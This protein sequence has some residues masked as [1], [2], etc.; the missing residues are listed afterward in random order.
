[1]TPWGKPHIGIIACNIIGNSNG[2]VCD[3]WTSSMDT[4]ERL[5]PLL[6]LDSEEAVASCPDV[7]STVTQTPESTHSQT[8][9]HYK[10]INILRGPVVW[11]SGTTNTS[12]EKVVF[13]RQVPYR[14]YPFYFVDRKNQIIG[15]GLPTCKQKNLKTLCSAWVPKLLNHIFRIFIFC[16][17]KVGS[18]L[19]MGIKMQFL[20]IVSKDIYC[21]ETS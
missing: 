6:L 11:N 20:E 9:D 21:S 1:M 16:F 7:P 3:V 10:S 4:D 14:I 19:P 18:F 13:Y 12:K 15:G 2:V 5:N 17:L 8:G